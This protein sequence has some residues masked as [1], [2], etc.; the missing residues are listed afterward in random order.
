MRIKRISLRGV[1]THNNTTLHLPESGVVVVTG[2]NG[3]GK[4]TLLIEAIPL[5][6]AGKS[7]RGTDLWSGDQG[8]AEV[9]TYDGEVSTRTKT[10]HKTS[11]KQSG[12]GEFQS[13]TK[14]TKSVTKDIK[15]WQRSCVLAGDDVATFSRSTDG[16]RK[17][18][19]ESVLKIDKFE[20]AL[21]AC[22]KELKEAKQSSAN[23]EAHLRNCKSSIADLEKAIAS[24]ESAKKLAK[25][26]GNL[27]ELRARKAEL[28]TLVAPLQAKAKQGATE[29]ANLRAK[30]RSLTADADRVK[31]AIKS[32]DKGACYACG[33]RLSDDT[34]K[35]S[36]LDELERIEAAKRLVIADGKQIVAD[37]V[38]AEKALNEA[39]PELSS[40]S[41][42]IS[43][44]EQHERSSAASDE[45]FKESTERLQSLREAL[46]ELE[47]TQQRCSKALET[48]QAC[49][50]VLGVKG[51][52]SK[53]LGEALTALE[54]SANYW[55]SK[56]SPDVVF[57]IKSEKELK[58]GE[59]S[60]ELTI[61]L[62]GVAGGHG[63]KGSS[64]GERKR[65]DIALTLALSEV[66]AAASGLEHSTLFFDEPFEGLDPGGVDA[67][68]DAIEELRTS[69]CVVIISHVEDIINSVRPDVLLKVDN[70]KVT[71]L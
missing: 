55:L 28:Q 16:E 59:T 10:G 41:T 26:E 47:S 2:S 62:T 25:P 68:V 14:G 56:F 40:V 53:V 63:Y 15:I 45:S 37:K 43:L 64:R 5:V 6:F 52:R 4:S 19:L 12:H 29:E 22:R 39:M 71:V 31:A 30:V 48:L 46:P 60:A 67:L 42:K 27:K 57:S 20:I 18:I 1:T 17:K 11:F 51:L 9:E 7:L 61:E 3:S 35:K 8:S 49:E 66:E 24:A 69:R 32:L 13:A 54:T 34:L 50:V 70:G 38:A 58:S 33:T 65:Q 23:A 44:H 21:E 36:K